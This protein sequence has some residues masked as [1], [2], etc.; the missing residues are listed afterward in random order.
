[1]SYYDGTKLLSLKDLSGAEPEIYLCCSNR[2]AG[3]TTYFGRLFVNR[4]L[5]Y[6]EKFG[7]LYR[8]NYELSDV[9]NKFFNELHSL[10][11]PDKTMES[12]TRAK[13][14]YTELF[15]NDKPCG[16]AMS[17]N[18]ADQLKKMSHLFADCQRILFDEFQSESNHYCDNELQKFIS[19]HTSIA[20][21]GGKQVRRVPVY[22]LGN[23]VSM[24]NPYFCALGISSRLKLNTNFM[25]GDGWVLEQGFNLSASELQKQSA[26]NRAFSQNEYVKYAAEK[27][28]LNDNVAFIDRP[29]GQSKYVCTIV[30][31]RNNYG[32]R[33]Y[34][35]SGII[36]CDTVADL[37]HPVKLSISTD[38]HN[39]NY[40][41]LRSSDPL[42]GLLRWYFEH[43]VFRFRNLECKNAIL[44]ICAYR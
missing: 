15:L 16:Y 42:I 40:I 12:K 18:N 43:G 6:G 25:R 33:E 5:S 41:M 36:Y 28:Y 30:Y 24:L 38:D 39:L 37:S 17:I 31:Q 44:E 21:G 26:F 9:A 10:F 22:M 11:F 20:R 27:S 23:Y 19:I 4:F 1:M 3:K 2:S 34:R 14:I 8:Y 7:L 32:I 13:G 35:E 29:A